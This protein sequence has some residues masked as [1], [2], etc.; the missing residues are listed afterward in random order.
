ML[1]H[2]R[3]IALYCISPVVSDTLQRFC[4]VPGSSVSLASENFSQ[5]TCFL[6]EVIWANC[7]LCEATYLLYY[8]QFI[9]KDPGTG[10]KRSHSLMSK[11][12]TKMNIP[13]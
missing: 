4:D 3:S 1:Q 10:V 5:L 6:E 8:E 2:R 12:D 11:C 9:W 13:L 7:Q